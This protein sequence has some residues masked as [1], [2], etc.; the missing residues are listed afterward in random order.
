MTRILR[1]VVLATAATAAAVL[2]PITPAF[3]ADVSLA[4]EVLATGDMA[5]DFEGYP[6]DGSSPAGCDPSGTSTLEFTAT[7]VATGPYPGTFTEH[8]V[9]RIGPQSPAGPDASLPGALVGEVLSFESEFTIT[10]TMGDV[11]GTKSLAETGIATNT[12]SCF[13]VSAEDGGGFAYT[14]LTDFTYTKR[15]VDVS[16]TYSARIQPT[17]GDVFRDSG[18]AYA[19]FDEGRFTGECTADTDYCRAVA[20][21]GDITID[22]SYFSGG[23]F[24]EA[25]LASDGTQPDLPPQPECSDGLDNDADSFIDYG[26]DPGCESLTDTTE[27]PNPPPAPECSDGL[28]NDADSFID[29]GSDPGCVSLTDTTESPNPRIS[30]DQCKRGGYL[31]NGF[32]NQ[33]DCESFS[34][35]QGKNPPAPR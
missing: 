28:D 19:G 15:S 18:T 5:F 12:G 20:A 9:I 27:S 30:K 1:R 35:T 17:V 25:F 21:T 24:V 16:L 22:N 31:T 33:G 23:G 6:V 29:Y 4:S 32:K 8:V 34:A 7:G 14:F 2:V 13:G 26:S 3:A 10:S 11:T